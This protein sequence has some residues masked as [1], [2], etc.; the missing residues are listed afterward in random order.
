M[1]VQVISGAS[2]DLW[3]IDPT[4]KAARVTLYDSLGV[5]IKNPQQV[6]TYS[7]CSAI[8][9][10][11]ATPTDVFTITGSGSK[12]VKVYRMWLSSLQ[13]TAGQNAWYI[14]KRNLANTAGTS[15]NLVEL[16]HD[17]NSAAATA[18]VLDYTV[19]PTIN[20]TTGKAW[21]GYIASPAPATAAI[22][23]YVQ[24]VDFIALFGQPLVLRGVAQVLAW[25]FD[26]AALPAGLAVIGGVTWTEE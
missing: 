3:T 25:N 2:A 24:Q 7:A 14:V 1:S 12:T 13:T 23:D 18:T 16:P 19:N 9:T 10:P 5:E 8:F 22:G 15:D 4:S 11:P 6:A 17:S 20:D 21:A 26:G